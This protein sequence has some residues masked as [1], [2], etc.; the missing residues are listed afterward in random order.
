M[1]NPPGTF[2]FDRTLQATLVTVQDTT[3]CHYIT[4]EELERL[5]EMRKEPV[6]EIFLVSIGAF[7]GVCLPAAQVLGQFRQDPNTLGIIGLI[8]LFLAAGTGA[9]AAVSGA[10]WKQRLKS[11]QSM[12]TSIR[13]RNK[14]QVQV[15]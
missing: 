2:S 9:I 3:L 10:L 11:H 1:A 8:T 15:S 6:M 7:I 12:T 4:D 5:S 13:G 14:V